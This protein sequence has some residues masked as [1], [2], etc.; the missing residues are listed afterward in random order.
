MMW[1]GMRKEVEKCYRK[2][3][4]RQLEID[5]CLSRWQDYFY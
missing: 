3:F 5:Y 1:T 4:V 2:G